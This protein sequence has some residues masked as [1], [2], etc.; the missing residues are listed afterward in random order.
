[1][2]QHLRLIPDEYLMFRYTASVE[3]LRNIADQGFYVPSISND[4]GMFLVFCVMM[5]VETIGLLWNNRVLF[6]TK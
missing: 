1:M 2:E 5:H 3:A 6:L 4:L